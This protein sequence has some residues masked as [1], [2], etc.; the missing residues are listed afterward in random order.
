MEVETK[1]YTLN[2]MLESEGKGGKRGQ[3]YFIDI[4]RWI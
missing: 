4:N 2:S 3:I 1:K